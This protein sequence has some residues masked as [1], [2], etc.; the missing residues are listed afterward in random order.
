MRFLRTILRYIRNKEWFVTTV[1]K[2]KPTGLGHCHN[3]MPPMH[4]KG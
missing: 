2:D 3:L 1:Q 4:M